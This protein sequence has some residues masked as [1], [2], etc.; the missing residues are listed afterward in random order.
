M[1]VNTKCKLWIK[2][3]ARLKLILCCGIVGGLSSDDV[4]VWGYVTNF[5]Y[6]NLNS[7]AI[8]HG[9]ISKRAT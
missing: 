8:W 4:Q 9:K 2:F 3:D 7:L 5:E 1:R 6:N